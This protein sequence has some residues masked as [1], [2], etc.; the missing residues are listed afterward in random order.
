MTKSCKKF[1]VAIFSTLFFSIHTFAYSPQSCNFQKIIDEKISN[2]RFS[3]LL[4][5]SD[6]S[7]IQNKNIFSFN[8]NTTY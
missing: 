4:I 3:E 6:L 8:G 5:T 2:N 7:R 1:S